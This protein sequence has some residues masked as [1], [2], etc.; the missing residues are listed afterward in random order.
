M[1]TLILI[2]TL[3][4]A[5]FGQTPSPT[6]IGYS[7]SED[8]KKSTASITAQSVSVDALKARAKTEKLK[9]L[10]ISYD[11]F[12]D[13]S[14]VMTK[15]ENL[16][17]SWEG[18]MAIFATGMV[19]PNKA[20]TMLMLQIGYQ[21]RGDKLKETPDK[22]GVVFTSNSSNW[23]FLKGD[24]N[25]YILFD[26]KRLELHPLAADR[27][28]LWSRIAPSVSVSEMLGYAITREELQSLMS[29]KKIEFKLGDTPP[30][31]WKPEWSRRIR[32][33]LTLTTLEKN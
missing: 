21:F 1:K 13:Q 12:K 24:T 15:P 18:G 31:K 27:D 26:D 3:A 28:I 19:G 29:A 5:A 22:Y 17:G 10:V 4:S 30:R 20:M 6:P 9:D 32:S 2:L 23:N 7:D 16:I 25:L 14:V 8:D 33:L 11:K